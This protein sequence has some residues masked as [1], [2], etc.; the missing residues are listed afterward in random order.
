MVV[1]FRFL[2]VGCWVVVVILGGVCAARL[3]PLLSLSLAVPGTSSAR[4]DAILAAHFGDNPD[5]TFVVVF[6]T[7][8]H[9]RP[10]LRD[11]ERRLDRAARLV[12]GGRAGIL[13]TAPG[14]VYGDLSSPLGLAAAARHT[15]QIRHAVSGS[16]VAY[17]TGEP[18]IQHDLR[19][20]LAGD[21]RRG[22]LVAVPIVLVILALTLGISLALAVPIAVA[23]GTITATLGIVYLI[24][25]VMTMVAYVPNLVEL[26]AIG[27]AVD[28]SYLLVNRLREELRDPERDVTD[29]IVTTMSTA[30]RAVAVSSLAV[31][32]GLSAILVVPVP[33]I[34]SVGIAGLLVPVC[35][36]LAT[37]TLQPALLA[38]LGRHAVGKG[39]VFTRHDGGRRLWGRL[40][41][42]VLR[43]RA[44]FL[45]GGVL[46][47][48]LAIS[49]I[50]DLQF[51]PGS[52][53][54]V[55]R[56][57]GSARGEFLLL[58]A[59]G[60]GA[61]TPVEVVIDSGRRDG[62]LTPEISAASGRLASEVASYRAVFLVET[63]TS[64]VDSSGRYRQVVVG[65]REQFGSQETQRLV[66][67]IATRDIPAAHFPATARVYLGGAPA[68]GVD[69][70]HRLASGFPLALLAAFCVTFVLLT[71]AFRS[72]ILA[73]VSVVLD[74]ASVAAA[75]G[76]LVV[77]FRFGIGADLVGLYR[78]AQIEG[79]IPVFVFATLFGLSMD[80]QVFIV[81]RMREAKD[82]G[83]GDDEAIAFGVERTGRVVSAAAA[84]MVATFCGFLVGR[85]ADLQEF[86]AGMALGV[87]LDVTILR[88][89][90]LPSVMSYLGRF[91]WWRPWSAT[92][93]PP[94]P[95]EGAVTAR[96]SARR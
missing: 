90:V 61:L 85:V 45:I 33:F 68:E 51:T 29:G 48:G 35:S 26:L 38:I 93:P 95:G 92:P 41:D 64:F 22:E 24:A 4:A 63:G 46:L 81:M 27:L 18:A 76:M 94:Q 47:V 75:Y 3:P 37:L 55:P 65:S 28:Y 86:G 56:S 59:V 30:G 80:Y 13:T 53:F 10:E 79:W 5:G 77:I 21:L 50:S 67:S 44:P 2:V 58:K 72:S 17:V 78:V 91:A 69:F 7:V 70:L 71:F 36:L 15:A 16:P 54:A 40:V 52:I 31:T 6:R 32:V 57:T 1:R 96:L 62:A 84:I 89:V 83:A 82:S 87:L 88:L 12:P 20:I 8:N 74:V 34:R 19:S 42:A 9:S 60:A 23:A 14:V 11:L 66:E 73:L 43:H 25:H 39:R 49:P